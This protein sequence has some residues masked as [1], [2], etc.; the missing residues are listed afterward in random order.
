MRDYNA[1][2]EAV[3]HEIFFAG[4]DPRYAPN[5]ELIESWWDGGR[6]AGSAQYEAA[7][8]QA[9]VAITTLAAAGLMQGDVSA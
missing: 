4:I 6:K 5:A 2:I 9:R 8:R 3:A 1:I 7:V